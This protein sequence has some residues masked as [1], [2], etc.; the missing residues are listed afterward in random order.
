MKRNMVP[1][2]PPAPGLGVVGRVAENRPGIQQRIPF[3]GHAALFLF[4]RP[5][6]GFVVNNQPRLPVGLLGEAGGHQS[7]GQLPL[8]AAHIPQGKAVPVEGRVVPENPLAIV[9]AVADGRLLPGVQAGQ[10]G[11][12]GGAHLGGGLR[13]RMVVVMP[14]VVVVMVVMMVMVVVVVVSVVVG[15]S[16]QTASSAPA[17]KIRVAVARIGV[18]I[19]AAVCGCQTDLTPAASAGLAGHRI[20]SGWLDGGRLDGRRLPAYRTAFCYNDEKLRLTPGPD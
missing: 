17:R 18:T 9:V 15:G 4:Q 7:V 6:H 3:P 19:C 5:Q 11:H 14:L 2:H 13:V 12:G 20:G 16:H 8:L 1:L 10:Q